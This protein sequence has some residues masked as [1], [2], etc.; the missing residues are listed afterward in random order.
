MIVTATVT[1]ESWVSVYTRIGDVF[2]WTCL[3]AA[4]GALLAPRRVRD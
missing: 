3:L 2:A 4:L 1:A